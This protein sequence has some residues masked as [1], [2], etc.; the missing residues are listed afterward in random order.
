MV[1]GS[2]CAEKKSCRK[3]LVSSKTLLC[4]C[5]SYPPAPGAVTHTHTHSTDLP[6]RAG[7]PQKH[8]A[9]LKVLQ[10]AGDSSALQ[11]FQSLTEDSV[12]QVQISTANPH[13]KCKLVHG[14]YYF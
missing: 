1:F 2:C 3:Q 4:R 10:A 6:V 13:E 11:T 12:P 14:T 9:P 8:C 7:Y 5:E